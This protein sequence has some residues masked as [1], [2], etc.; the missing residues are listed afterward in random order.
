MMQDNP[1]PVNPYDPPVVQPP[2]QQYTNSEKHSGLGVAAFVLSLVGAIGIF[3][4]VTLATIWTIKG[5]MDETSARA[6]ILGLIL[7]GLIG[8]EGLAFILGIA[9]WLQ[10]NRKHLFAIIGVLLSLITII[11][12]VGLII[13][14]LTVG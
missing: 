10:K 5:E 7:I 6:I 8:L 1:T 13:V 3:I 14:G 2:S 11:G 9:G 4:C 12:I